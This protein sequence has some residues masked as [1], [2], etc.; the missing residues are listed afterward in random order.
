M[1]KLVSLALAILTLIAVVA[2]TGCGKTPANDTTTTATDNGNTTK[3]IDTEKTISPAQVSEEYLNGT[4]DGETRHEGKFF[5]YLDGN[6]YLIQEKDDYTEKEFC[7]RP[8]APEFFKV[9]FA[10]KVVRGGIVA[11][12]TDFTDIVYALKGKIIR[13][14]ADVQSWDALDGKLKLF[15]IGDIV[16]IREGETALIMNYMTGEKQKMTGVSSVEYSTD[17]TGIAI[18]TFAGKN[19]IVL[20]D[21][22]ITELKTKYIQLPDDVDFNCHDL[23]DDLEVY[24]KGRTTECDA[25]AQMYFY[26]YA[27]KDNRSYTIVLRKNGAYVGMIA[28][29]VIAV[30]EGQ[31]RIYYLTDSGEVYV[32]DCVEGEAQ[33]FVGIPVYGLVTIE[34]KVYAISDAN[35]T[36][37]PPMHGYTNLYKGDIV[38]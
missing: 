7:G 33:M 12:N 23:P 35:H 10:I 5:Y 32:Y 20:H 27:N 28:R 19:Q 16:V 6:G 4:W 11:V 25:E 34:D 1:K 14:L 29:N 15:T 31:N 21:G 18:A 36:D 24:P 38:G 13:R 9:G 22:T 26:A 37:T 30:E 2:F 3:V 17:D 8:D